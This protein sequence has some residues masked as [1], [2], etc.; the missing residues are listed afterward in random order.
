M[1]QIKI[2]RKKLIHSGDKEKNFSEIVV[3]INEKLI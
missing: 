1:N 3:I 2:I